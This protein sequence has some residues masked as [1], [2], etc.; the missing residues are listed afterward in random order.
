MEECTYTNAAGKVVPIQPSTEPATYVEQVASQALLDI[1]KTDIPTKRPIW[2]KE[3]VDELD[4][5]VASGKTVS[6]PHYPH[7][8]ED[9]ALALHVIQPAITEFNSTSA[10]IGVV[11]AISPWV[12]H[13]MRAAGATRV[14]SVDFNP[15]I[16]CGVPWIESKNVTT[17]ASEE[18]FY[19]LLVS[20]S[21]I[22]HSGLGRY[23]D[24]LNANGDVE[25]ME[26]MYRALRPGGFLLLGVPTFVKD[27]QA[28]NWHRLYGPKRLAWLLD[29]GFRFKARVWDGHVLP[30]W[31]AVD[32]APELFVTAKG[33]ADW[34]NQHVLIL[35]KAVPQEGGAAKI[36]QQ[37]HAELCSSTDPLVSMF[38]VLLFLF[39]LKRICMKRF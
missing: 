5:L 20:F 14:I 37:Q 24:P 4:N 22:E 13:L 25:T 29:A 38:A 6:C 9:I 1:L 8:G 21:G 17:F 10:N 3:V 16:I 32:K 31:S 27:Y 30:G 39:L 11:S 15:P 33:I 2:N 12:E 19:D 23:G 36:Q 7:S 34:Q 26:Q 28:Q 18:D 35:Q